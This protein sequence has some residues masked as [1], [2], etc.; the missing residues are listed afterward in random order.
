MPSCSSAR[1]PFTSGTT[2][3]IPSASRNAADLSMQTAPP[4]TACGTSSLLARVPTEKR[5]RSRLPAASASGVASATTRPSASVVP[6]ER[7]EA[8]GRTSSKPRSASSSSVT[9]PTPPVAP[10]TPTLGM[11]ALGLGGIELEGPVQLQDCSL[12][13]LAAHVTGD[14]DRRGDHDL[15][16]DSGCRKR[17]ESPRRHTRMALHPR[18][19]HTHL[20]QVVPGGPV[21]VEPVERIACRLVVLRRRREQDLRASAH[22]RVHVH[23][24]LREDGEQ[25][26]RVDAFDAVEHFLARMGDSG[27]QRLLEHPFVLLAN[28]GAVLRRERG[29]D[30]QLDVVV[31][32][33]L[34]RAYL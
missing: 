11:L 2:S 27:D 20:A 9:A 7:S 23:A 14:L 19:D 21:D 32:C 16:L 29:A 4:R 13:V 33:D 8:K 25:P 3:G 6:A 28:P 12:D 26:R 34:D 17:L 30:V 24:G 22:D 18:A 10:I 1:G 31:P 5:Q 15:E